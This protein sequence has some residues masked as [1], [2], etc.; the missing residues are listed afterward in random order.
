MPK[1][2]TAAAV[3]GG[4]GK[5]VRRDRLSEEVVKRELEEDLKR[6]KRETANEKEDGEEVLE[7]KVLKKTRS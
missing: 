6:L 5:G 3:G 7:H 1:R 4:G 2:K